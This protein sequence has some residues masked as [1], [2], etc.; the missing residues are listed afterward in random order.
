MNIVST[1][2]AQHS[3]SFNRRITIIMTVYNNFEEVAHK[4]AER[5][6]P[7]IYKYRDWEKD[8]HE[9]IITKRDLYFAQPH[10]LNDPYDVR[11]P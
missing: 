7:I 9:T 10:T 8:F 11:P 4:I 2:C 6:P 3:F 5:T 1:F